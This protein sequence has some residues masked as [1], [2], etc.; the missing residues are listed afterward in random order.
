MRLTD[1]R[2][3]V[4]FTDSEKNY[5]D[6]KFDDS[7]DAMKYFG[8]QLRK[9]F[10]DGCRNISVLDN[11]NNVYY[12]ALADGNKV[13]KIGDKVKLK[14]EYTTPG[15]REYEYKITNLNEHSERAS[16]MCINSGMFLAPIS[17]VGLEMIA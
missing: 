9:P 13:F 15:E 12:V 11:E 8:K 17:L 2:Y 7:G 10:P 4:R 14:D 1:K 6:V 5:R 3:I 16:I